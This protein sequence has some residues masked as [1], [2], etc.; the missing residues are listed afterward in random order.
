LKAHE[1]NSYLT[2]FPSKVELQRAVAFGGADVRGDG[3]LAGVRLRFEVWQEEAGFLLP[4]VWVRVFGLRR[5]LYEFLDLWAVGSMLGFTQTVDMETTRKSNFGRVQVA[6]LNPGLIPEQL[7]VVIGDHYFEVEF[8]VERVGIDENGEE[9]EFE[10]PNGVEEGD[11]EDLV[12]GGQRGEEEEFERMTKK[13]KRDEVAEEKGRVEEN[14]KGAEDGFISWR[15]QVQNM[16]KVE[17]EAFLR[18]KAGEILN[19]AADE[20]IGEVADK[21]MEEKDEDQQG[22]EEVGIGAGTL[23]GV[24]KIVEMTDRVKE[25]AN[26]PEANKGQIR[27]SPRL[28][29]SR[30]EHVLAKAKERAVRKNLEFDGGNPSSP[31]LF[32][33]SSDLALHYLQ[34]LGLNLGSSELDQ[35]NNLCS[36]LN[37][38]MGGDVSESGGSDKE[39][40][41]WDSD[42]ESCEEIEK[43]ALRSLCGELVEEIFDESSYPLNSELGDLKRKGKSHAKSWL[44][45]TCKIRRVKCLKK[46]SNERNL[47][48]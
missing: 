7:D 25:A 11:A 38:G 34:Q 24:D 19:M 26:V 6:V 42:E 40:L 3:V 13:Q 27:A 43:R 29:R 33:V 22:Q 32:F 44:S 21:V 41:D 14:T 35:D 4:K 17:F 1:E 20:V 10:W 2:K 48:E 5:E 12:K 18:A 28:Q 23:S 37:H 30:D 16:S 45:K 39:W 8:E 31:S 9:A 15:E 47:L 36:L 46:V